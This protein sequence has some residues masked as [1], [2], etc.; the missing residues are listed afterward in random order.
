MDYLIGYTPPKIAVT[1]EYKS[2]IRVNKLSSE[3]I[4]R[5]LDQGRELQMAVH[6]MNERM[7]PTAEDLNRILY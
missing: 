2:P 7:R 3:E 6:K 4:R 5:L 1:D